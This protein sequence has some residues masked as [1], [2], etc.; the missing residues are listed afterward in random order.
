MVSFFII[1]PFIKTSN[2]ESLIR[3]DVNKLNL[4]F[5]GHTISFDNFFN[6]SVFILL[7][8][9]VT[10]LVTQIF[11]KIWCG[12]ICPQSFSSDIIVKIASL[13]KNKKTRKIVDILLSVKA[14]FILAT[15][16][17]FYFVSPYDFFS[18]LT[19]SGGKVMITIWSV[20]FVALFIDF[21]FI[22]YK[23]CKTICPYARAQFLM[24]DDNT[25]YVG[26]LHGEDSKCIE[27]LACIK[28]CP[29]QIDPRK[30]PNGSCIYCENCIKACD[31]VMKKRGGKS[32]LGY[33][34]G[35]AAKFHPGRVNLIITF[36]V[37]LLFV[38][39]FTYNLFHNQPLM[40]QIKEVSVADNGSVII[41]ANLQNNL[42]S[43]V[44]INFVLPGSSDIINPNYIV[45]G[46]KS[47]KELGMS[48][49]TKDRNIKTIVLNI[50][51]NKGNTVVKNIQLK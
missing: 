27:C 45:L 9:F 51:N 25:L 11:G 44:L 7:I 8:V 36:C 14:A 26:M 6:V 12:W 47:E 43:N 24:S 15:L 23:W 50:S 19:G 41:K 34:W 22:R 1:V 46:M 37:A 32:I 16:C 5:F 13:F 38:L 49:Q 4:F 18:T 21:A 39:L 48:I 40:V 30:T 28:S 17:M 29:V 20:L 33:N 31:K 35:S 10:I 42:P 3:F 2:G